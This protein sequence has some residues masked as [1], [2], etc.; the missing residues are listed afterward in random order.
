MLRRLRD[1]GIIAEKHTQENRAVSASE[2]F[3]Q[4]PEAL[5][6]V[7]MNIATFALNTH[8]LSFAP[9]SYEGGEDDVKIGWIG[10]FENAS[11]ARTDAKTSRG[12]AALN[13]NS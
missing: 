11:A 6:Q 5:P 3:F 4:N 13:S 8:L 1:C 10:F 7:G 12:I 2:F 9:R